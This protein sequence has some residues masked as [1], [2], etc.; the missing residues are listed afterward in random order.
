LC[1]GWDILG[2]TTM[3]ESMGRI[4]DMPTARTAPL[5]MSERVGVV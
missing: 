1:D 3:P 4:D 5:T 2:S